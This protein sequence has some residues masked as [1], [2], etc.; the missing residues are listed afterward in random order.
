M[1]QPNKFLGMITVQW[2]N[3]Y[4]A[5]SINGLVIDQLECHDVG[6]RFEMEEGVNKSQLEPKLVNAKSLGDTIRKWEIDRLR[7]LKLRKERYQHTAYIV[8]FAE[9]CD[10]RKKA[11]SHVD[12]LS[13]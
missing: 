12:E 7:G 2:N 8:Q 6:V 11:S 10:G 3:T 5:T 1:T 9:R 4:S 13:R